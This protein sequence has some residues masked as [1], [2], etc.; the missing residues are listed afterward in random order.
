MPDNPDKKYPSGVTA[1]DLNKTITR[2][3]LEVDPV[4][5]ESKTVATQTVHYTRTAT[6]DEVTGKVA[7][8]NWATTDKWASYTAPDKPGYT[9]SQTSVEEATPAVT[10][11]DTTVTITYLSLIHISEPT[12]RS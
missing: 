4:T 7:Y 3:I 5:K 10:D 6:V 2:T 12:R 8:T 1:T 9:P 11:K